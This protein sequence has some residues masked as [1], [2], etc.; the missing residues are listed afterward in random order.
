MEVF[1]GA[2]GGDVKYWESIE[3]RRNACGICS[4]ISNTPQTNQARRASTQVSPNTVPPS[5]PPRMSALNRTNRV[6]TIPI[7]P[8]HRRMSINLRHHARRLRL[9]AV[10]RSPIRRIVLPSQIRSRDVA[11]VVRAESR[12][13]G[14]SRWHWWR[15]LWGIRRFGVDAEGLAVGAAGRVG[16][17]LGGL[18]ERHGWGGARVVFDGVGEGV[19]ALLSWAA[20]WGSWWRLD[21][22]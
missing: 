6:I 1:G 11:V 8:A 12:T 14:R 4:I 10:H 3:R 16:G 5:S 18:I 2:V 19:A 17:V 7:H 9:S 20:R 15:G 21:C 13:I 22:R